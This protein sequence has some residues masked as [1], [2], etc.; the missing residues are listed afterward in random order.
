MEKDNKILIGL[1]SVLGAIGIYFYYKKNQNLNTASG[2]DS[3]L[4]SASVSTKSTKTT[5]SSIFDKVFS[6][7]TKIAQNTQNKASSG[8]ITSKEPVSSTS[9]EL[10]S[11][12]GISMKDT[13]LENQSASLGSLTTAGK[14]Y[15]NIA[16]PT[17]YVDP[18]YYPET[19]VFYPQAEGEY[20]TTNDIQAPSTPDYLS[21]DVPS[22]ALNGPDP[23]LDSAVYNWDDYYGFGDVG[24]GN[25]HRGDASDPYGLGGVPSS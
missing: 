2:T 22:W 10:Q 3:V 19:I 12:P 24:G 13:T 25:I 5:T 15:T 1:A 14:D 18:N 8:K 16:N 6:V 21:P 7:G 4:K 23:V 9:Y 11:G 20:T 17:G